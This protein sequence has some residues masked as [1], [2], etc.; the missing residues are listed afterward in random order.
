MPERLVNAIPIGV[1]EAVELAVSND[2]ALKAAELGVKQKGEE[3]EA[4][5]GVFMPRVSL[6]LSAGRSD[7]TGGYTESYNDL[8]GLLALD[9]N[10]F[11]G[12]SDQESL[13]RARHEAGKARQGVEQVRR[14]VVED[15]ETAFNFYKATWELLPV[16]KEAV[17]KNAE[18]VSGYADQFR[19]GRRSLLDLVSAQNALFNSQQVYLNGQVAH[20][21]S[22][23]RVLAPL[24]LLLKNL[25]ITMDASGNWKHVSA[26]E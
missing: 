2:H 6:E 8:S 1:A 26:T 19:M 17:D 15:M 14:A 16:L 11:N 20:T 13:R 7:N 5:Q 21:F 24:A 18:V 25:G 9:M 23:Y 10:L 12:G 22:Y 3:L 4:A